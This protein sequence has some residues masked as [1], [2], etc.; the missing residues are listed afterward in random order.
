MSEGKEAFVW[1]VASNQMRSLRELIQEDLGVD[2]S[3]WTLDKPPVISADGQ[4]MIALAIN[5]EGD[6]EAFVTYLPEP[7]GGIYAGIAMLVWLDRRRSARDG[8]SRHSQS[9]CVR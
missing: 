8:R 9:R 7:A 6:A 3:G 1:S 4:T 2:L 5:P